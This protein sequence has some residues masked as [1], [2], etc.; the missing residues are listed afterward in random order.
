MMRWLEDIT[1]L[2]AMSWNKLQELVTD[3]E[4]WR[5]AAHGPKYDQ[6]GGQMASIYFLGA[7]RQLESYLLD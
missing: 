6:Y 1:N 2:M 7:L 5:V 3:R 4:A